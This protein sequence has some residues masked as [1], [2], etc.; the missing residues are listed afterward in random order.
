M[1]WHEQCLSFRSVPRASLGLGSLPFGVPPP[2]RF[3]APLH[4]IPALF[5][6]EHPVPLARKLLDAPTARR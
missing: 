1:L 4:F 6:P 2:P 3:A 5:M